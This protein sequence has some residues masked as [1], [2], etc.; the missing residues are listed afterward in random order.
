MATVKG[1]WKKKAKKKKVKYL[2]TAHSNGLSS[3]IRV[4]WESIC[5]STK[6]MKINLNL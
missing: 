1:K 5:G 3:I 6:D 4:L 2:P